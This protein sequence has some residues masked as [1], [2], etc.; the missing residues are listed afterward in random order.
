MKLFDIATY[1]FIKTKRNKK[2]IFFILLLGF[3]TV[4]LIGILTFKTLY[5]TNLNLNFEQNIS[6]RRLAVLPNSDNVIKYGNDYNYDY[7]S[8]K[9]LDHVLDMYRLEHDYYDFESSTFKND[10][11]TGFIELR[12]GSKYTIPK[13]SNGE[14]FKED[15]TG[16]AI[17]A[18]N[19]YPSIPDN[20]D[21]LISA[22]YMD[23]D[24]LIGTTFDLT[25]DVYKRIDDKLTKVD[26]YQKTFKIIGTFDSS[27]TGDIPQTCYISEK[28]MQDIHDSVT[29][30][31]FANNVNSML[32]LVDE[33]K[34]LDNVTKEIEALGFTVERELI[35]DT[36]L[37]DQ[38]IKTGTVFIII[39]LVSIGF[40]T[41]FYIKKT[42]E[43]DRISTGILKSIGYS[44]NDIVK[45]QLLKMFNLTVISIVFG[46]VIFLIL[47]IFLK[48]YFIDY[49]IYNNLV[50]K[51]S[52]LDFLIC[53][54][55]VL[56]IPLMIELIFVKKKIKYSAVDL[57]RGNK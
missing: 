48:Q 24:K 26:V 34:N 14:V 36:K 57:L 11:Y 25:A 3:C 49:L 19:F 4:I 28:D 15:D 21:S 29:K 38:L 27:K 47:I 54:V 37:L 53:T 42:N 2:N 55:V 44:N 40:L 31:V 17:C 13:V 45:F 39:V 33:R 32:V 12:Y 10:S 1:S 6:G 22:N 43:D 51:I 18:K 20:T 35:Q 50:I 5:F 46:F 9:N 30:D 23:G 52:F 7:S 16:V 56:L 8:I 41:L